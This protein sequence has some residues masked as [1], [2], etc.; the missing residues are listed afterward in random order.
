MVFN[1][2]WAWPDR[3]FFARRQ[4]EDGV[5]WA[6]GGERYFRPSLVGGWQFGGFG[7]SAEEFGLA[8]EPR[9]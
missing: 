7:L 8:D 5:S 2:A 4:S 1:K 3:S 6:V 9:G